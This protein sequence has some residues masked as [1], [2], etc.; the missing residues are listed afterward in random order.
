MK[1]ETSTLKLRRLK[2]DTDKRA[3][4]Y[5]H[6]QN[7]VYKAKGFESGIRVQVKTKTNS[8]IAM[9][10]VISVDYL[11]PNEVG[12]SEYVWNLLKGIDGETVSLLYPDASPS[13]SYIRGKIH[14]KRL[15]QVMMETIIKDII[16][17]QLSDVQVAA[18]LTACTSGRLNIDEITSLTQAMIQSGKQLT[19]AEKIV[20]DK[21]CVGGVPGNRTTMIVVPIVAAFGL[22]IPKTSSRSITSPAGTADTM[23][24]FAP[25]DLDYSRMREVVQR[26]KGCLVWGGSSALSPA[27]D[28][29][30]AV[31]RELDLDSREQ[32][33]ASILS[34]KIAAGA[35][36]LLI[37]IPVG[38]SAK[39]RSIAEAKTLKR[40][41]QQLSKRLGLV[42]K[43]VISDGSQPVGNGIGPALEARDVW[44]VLNN[45]KTASSLLRDRA[46]YLAGI[47]LEF[48]PTVKKGQGETIARGILESG[49]ALEKFKAICEAQGGMRTIPVAPCQYAYLS[50]RSGTILSVDNRR[51]S[52]L[53][54][55]AGAP[56][57]KVAGIDLHVMIGDRV[58]AKD[59]ILTIHAAST[60]ELDYAISYL[61]SNN[62]F[63]Q[64]VK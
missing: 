28:M 56:F 34:K 31:E 1:Q 57:D 3:V 24:V 52:H 61:E 53:A 62:T 38:A 18:F 25:V 8:I 32:M 23:E 50:P 55:A 14:G 33:V 40:L 17:G 21:H 10:A 27:D 26:E 16:R 30:I 48:S 9:L 54:K 58:K 60:G 7:S 51:L 12:V 63:M 37:D 19:W 13:L 29:L 35:T 2:I 44:R 15:T 36:H 46:L 11:S 45:E 4:V 43:V 39:V 47:L 22:T 42:V 64:F 5:V 20:V 6:Y 41:I 49:Q 59:P